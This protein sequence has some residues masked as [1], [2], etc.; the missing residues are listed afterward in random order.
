MCLSST[1]DG[2]RLVAAPLLA[3]L[4][5]SDPFLISL[6]VVANRLPWLLFGLAGGAIADR[7]R[8]KSLMV[9]VDLARCLLVAALAGAVFF[10]LAG[11]ALL[12][13]V[14]FCLGVG[15]AVFSAATQGMIPEVVRDP[16]ELSAANGTLFVTQSASSNF[17][18][19]SIGGAL[20]SLAHWL[21]FLTDAVSFLLASA[22]VARI[23]TGDRFAP[24][25]EV[26]MW[27]AVREGVAWCKDKPVVVALL[28]VMGVVNFAQSGVLAIMVI[29]VTKDLG[30]SSAAF[31]VVMSVSGAGG[32]AGGALAPVA[33][34]TFGFGYVLPVGVALAGPLLL[35]MIASNSVILLA[36]CLFF[37]SFLGIMVSVLVATL[38]QKITPR[39][40][41]GRVASVQAFIAM[42][43]AMPGGALLAGGVAALLG[44]RV[45]FVFSGALCILLYIAMAGILRPRVLRRHIEELVAQAG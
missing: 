2:I 3:V 45:V 9:M 19:P 43:L 30:A 33:D 36:V 41:A 21:P 11:I 17:L 24:N 26:G 7:Y 12:A 16:D 35:L 32:I 31:G 22:L 44:P 15:E 20:F 29:Y 42:G 18:G 10:G 40:L 25:P 27:R 14:S 8:R 23:E 5:T 38:R 13:V 37:N 34:R 39:R 4:L 1:G 28:S 6:V